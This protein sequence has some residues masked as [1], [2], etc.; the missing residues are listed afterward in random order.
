MKITVPKGREGQLSFLQIPNNANQSKNY[1]QTS[2]M[3]SPHLSKSA[4]INVQLLNVQVN[5]SVSP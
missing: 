2:G 4:K 5:V 3:D 1:M